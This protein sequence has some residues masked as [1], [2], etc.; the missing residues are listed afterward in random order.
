[1]TSL[2]ISNDRIRIHETHLM[3]D[4]QH[5]LLPL[6]ADI[7]LNC[8]IPNE[9]TAREATEWLKQTK[10][11]LTAEMIQHLKLPTR[12]NCS[13]YTGPLSLEQQIILYGDLR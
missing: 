11:I 8:V 4:A 9:P 13:V 3:R 5:D 1:M 6:F 12:T 2:S 10:G 7:Q